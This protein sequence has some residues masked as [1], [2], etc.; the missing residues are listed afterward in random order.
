MHHFDVKK[1]VQNSFKQLSAGYY[2]A[3][4]KLMSPNCSFTLW[5]NNMPQVEKKS[6]AFSIKLSIGVV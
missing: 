5:G 6:L 3:A 4:T 1:R 2:Q